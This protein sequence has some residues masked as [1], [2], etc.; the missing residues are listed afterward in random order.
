MSNKLKLFSIAIF[1]F[2]LMSCDHN[3]THYRYIRNESDTTITVYNPDFKT[4]EMILEGE[5]G[6]IYSFE[7]LDT[8]Q[9]SEPCEWLGDSLVILNVVD[10]VCTKNPKLEGNWVMTFGGTDKERT[11]SCVMTVENSDF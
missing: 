5:E 9:E 6:L 8:K 10:S 11:Q 7:V 2:T 4:T 3:L 1:G